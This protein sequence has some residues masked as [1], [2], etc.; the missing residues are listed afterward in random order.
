MALGLPALAQQS[1]QFSRPAGQDPAA[2]ANAF[3]PPSHQAN[4]ASFS[5][6]VSLFGGGPTADFDILPGAPGPVTQNT[7][8][9]WQKFL[10]DKK[11]WTLLTPEEVL[12]L[13]TPEKLLGITDPD[14][15]QLSAQDRY[16]R[17]QEHRSESAAT[18]FLHQANSLAWHADDPTA[19]LFQDPD[20]NGRLPETPGNS[21]TGRTL[22]GS[23][24]SLNP[25]FN[26][27]PKSPTEMNQD[28]ES[29]WVSPFNTPDQTPKPTPEQMAGMDRFRALLEAPTP[30]KPSVLAGFSGQPLPASDPNMQPLPA[31]NPASGGVKPLQS[32]IATPTGLLPLAPVT[33][34]L[35]PPPKKSALVQAPP[36]MSSSPQNPTLPQRQF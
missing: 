25:F 23:T 6:P 14:E 7:S 4:P 19:K 3:L 15:D 17:R 11:N 13:P 16:L 31:Y 26:P 35:P 1:I 27:L 30:D 34:Q 5:A 12:G 33:G 29:T 32:D 8:P 24:R 21:I 28:I 2:T 9:Q 18:N 20:A 10:D 22:P 36:W